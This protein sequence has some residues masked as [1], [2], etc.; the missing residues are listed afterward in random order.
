MSESKVW[1]VRAADLRRLA[2]TTREAERERKML[3]LA[4]QLEEI[5]RAQGSAENGARGDSPD[6]D[7]SR[8]VDR[9]R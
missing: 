6:E 1:K 2:K 3:V 9:A 4:E 7:A 5:E 8:P